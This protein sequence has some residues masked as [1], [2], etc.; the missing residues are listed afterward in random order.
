MRTGKGAVVLALAAVLATGPGVASSAAA[1]TRTWTVR[2]GGAITATAGK[3]TLT[4]TKTGNTASC[5][6]SRMSGTLRSGNGL[7]GTGIATITSAAFRCPIPI[8][9]YRLTPRGLPWHLNLSS[10]D[11]GTGVSRGTI[12]HLQLAFSIIGAP[13]SAVINATS[14]TTAD[15][16]MAITYSDHEA[17]LETL[18]TGSDLHW[19]HVQHCAG[20]VANGDPAALSAVYAISPPQTITSP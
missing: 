1:T 19:Y 20:L 2:P 13:C 9:A 17:K 3:T 16:V 4:D 6:S 5:D 7:P 8:G 11:R 18:P 12:S 14:G 10:F 15:G